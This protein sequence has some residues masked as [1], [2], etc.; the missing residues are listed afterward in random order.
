VQLECDAVILLM[1]GCA[2]PIHYVSPS[3]DIGYPAPQ[4]PD[5]RD[6]DLTFGGVGQGVDPVYSPRRDYFATPGGIEH[7]VPATP[8]TPAMRVCTKVLDRAGSRGV[9]W[10][11]EHDG[12]LTLWGWPPT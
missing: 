5:S 7:V 9:C 8:V 1:L 4:Y 2:L 11:T 10:C 6:N 12:V 3:Q